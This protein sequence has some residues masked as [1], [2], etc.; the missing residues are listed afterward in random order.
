M[1]KAPP[2]PNLKEG[3]AI[4]PKTYSTDGI[5]PMTL[6]SMEHALKGEFHKTQ[7]CEFFGLSM[8]NLNKLLARATPVNISDNKDD[9]RYHI[10]DISTIVNTSA[11]STLT[12][13]EQLVAE[14]IELAKQDKEAKYLRNK[15]TRGE[16]I[17]APNVERHIASAF[18]VISRW[19]DLLP[20]IFEKKGLIRGE[21]LT[22][23][24]DM[25]NKAK[26]QLYED[27]SE[28]DNTK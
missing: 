1:F 15:V 26:R 6:I 27:L 5:S 22:I 9:W 12:L 13:N 14:K 3:T 24:D 8:Y 7:L 28:F 17:P 16:L 23:F 20:D 11:K 2:P 4:V 10:G 19:I 21:S 18:K 25:V